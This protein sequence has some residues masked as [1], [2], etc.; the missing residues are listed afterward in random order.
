MLMVKIF[1]SLFSFLPDLFIRSIYS[2]TAINPG[3]KQIDLIDIAPT[4]PQ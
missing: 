3:I 4:D 1:Y 2:D